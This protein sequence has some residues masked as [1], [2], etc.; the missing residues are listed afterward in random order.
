MKLLRLRSYY[1]PEI[2]ASTHLDRDLD[3]MFE[4]KGILS[5]SYTPTPTR[6]VDAETI[7]KYKKIK[8]EETHNGYVII[9]RFNMFNEGRNILQ[10]TARFLCCNIIQYIL[11]IREKDVDIVYSSSTPPTQGL[12]NAL[13]AKRLSKKEKKKIPF[14]YNLQDVFPDSIVNAGITKKGSLIWKIGRKMENYVYKC[15]DKIIVISEG[16]KQNILAKGVPEEKVVVVSNWVD[17][18]DTVPVKRDNNK[19]FSE[20]PIDKS[21]FIVSYAGNLGEAQGADVIIDAAKNLMNV[22]DIQ[23]AIFGGGS[24]FDDIKKRVEDEKIENLFVTG[25]LPLERV[26]EV[27]SVGNVSLIICKPGTGKAGLPSKV[28]NIM[29]CD[30]PVIA[31]FDAES[32]LAQVIRE[33]NAGTVV[34]PG[35]SKALSDEIY[36]EYEKWKSD[37]DIKYNFRDYVKKTASKEISVEK[38]YEVISDAVCNR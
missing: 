3:D 19:L 28:W 18:N 30:T 27:Y 29:A 24:H 17:I 34:E 38:Y 12:V 25:L 21:K 13:V 36:K 2:M 7:K 4:E 15:A 16:F 1:D 32:D 6:G 20:F 9:N 35:N 8:Y 14:V 33:A 31:A 26:S 10:R 22:T 37:R 23:F 11:G 5:V